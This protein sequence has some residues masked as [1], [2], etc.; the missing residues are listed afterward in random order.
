VP[1]APGG[2]TDIMVRVIDKIGTQ[3]KIFPS[4]W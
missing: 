4:R 3:L 1:Y 2:G